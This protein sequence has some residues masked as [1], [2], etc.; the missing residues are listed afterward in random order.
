MSVNLNICLNNSERKSGGILVELN[1]LFIIIILI[2]GFFSNSAHAVLV[3]YKKTMA[4][5]EMAR[6]VRFT[7]SFLCRDLSYNT[8][9]IRL[10]KDL[11][12]KDQITCSKTFENVRC[13]WYVSNSIL[14]RKTIREAGFGVNPFS[15]PEIQIIDFRT[16]RLANNRL[17][18]LMTM[19]HLETGLVRKI[20][21]VIFL[22][23]G[24]IT[25]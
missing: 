8:T 7:K 2:C 19:K 16:E 12:G 15:N 6:C 1:F 14:Y 18:I 22:N 13:Y 23:N 17:G 10:S 5:M 4:D 9:Q 21:F 3:N 20:P 11:N 25:D 24:L